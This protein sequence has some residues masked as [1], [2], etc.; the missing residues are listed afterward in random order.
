MTRLIFTAG[1]T[2]CYFAG[3]AMMVLGRWADGFAICGVSL[4]AFA[5]YNQ[6]CEK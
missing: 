1:F 2:A 3:L 5:I 4:M 6:G